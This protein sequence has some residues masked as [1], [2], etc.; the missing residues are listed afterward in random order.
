MMT[1][2]ILKKNQIEKLYLELSKEFNFFAPYN[3]K[4]N[5]VFKKILK[6]EEIEL[7]STEGKQKDPKK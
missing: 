1:Q 4:G 5:I 3:E 7:N 6:S 2:K